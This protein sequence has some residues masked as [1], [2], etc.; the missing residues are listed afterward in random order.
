LTITPGQ[1]AARAEFYHQLGVLTAA[2]VTVTSALDQIHRS[3]PARSYR[4]PVR[5]IRTQILEGSNLTESFRRLGGWLPDF[6]LALIHAGEESGR[7]DAS[8][9]L[10]AEYYRD[11]A[12]IARQLIG[13][14]LYP[15][16]LL[17]LAVFIFPFPQFF[18][19]GNLLVYLRQTLGILL[20]LYGVVAAI[21]YAS[22]SR[23]SEGWRA[24][25]EA[26]LH[27]VPVLGTARRSLAL[28]RLCAALESL[29]MAGVSIFEA[30]ELA[31]TASGSPAL[32]REVLGWR[33][34]LEAGVTPAEALQSSRGFPEIFVGQYAAGEISGTLEENLRRL[35]GYFQEEGTRKLHAVAQW[36][37]RLIY[38]AVVIIVAVKVVGFWTNYFGQLQQIGNF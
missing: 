19:S 5:Q 7:L 35:H 9:R 4:E 30:W 6:D 16:L 11:R 25:V 29:L 34:E 38:F 2:G 3:P 18:L 8:L 27:P 12:R 32:R 1:F 14:L 23:H 21:I 37:P 10:L 15:G 17:H 36:T 20:P 13:D 24:T 22:H 33:K 28:A 26:L 31:A